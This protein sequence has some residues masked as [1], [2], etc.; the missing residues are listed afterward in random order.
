MDEYSFPAAP[1]L[2]ASNQILIS[3]QPGRAPDY[4]F[5]LCTQWSIQ[6]LFM[7]EGGGGG[8]GKKERLPSLAFYAYNLPYLHTRVSVRYQQSNGI[9]LYH[10]AE[11]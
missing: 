1:L 4:I 5:E 11:M 3:F 6:P 8:G 9:R 10:S 7:K 2:F